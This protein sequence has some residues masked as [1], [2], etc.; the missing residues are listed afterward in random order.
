MTAKEAVL[1]LLKREKEVGDAAAQGVDAIRREW[2]LAL[3]ELMAQIRQWLK[4]AE[5]EKLLQVEEYTASLR[6]ERLGNYDAPALKIVTPRGF[7]L[8]VKPKARFVVGGMGRVDLDAMPK[9][10]ILV[11]KDRTTWQVAKQTGE[12][13]FWSFADLDENSFWQALNELMM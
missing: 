3:A 7:A 6:E 9:L 10:R 12:H 5:Q 1:E 2:L 8:N 4:A 13:G 11:R